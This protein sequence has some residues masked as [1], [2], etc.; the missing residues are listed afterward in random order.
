M[1]VLLAPGVRV[2]V[3]DHMLELGFR[4]V[5][6]DLVGYRTGSLNEGHTRPALRASGADPDQP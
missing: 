4:Y 2:R 3:A 5:T 1:E 6:V